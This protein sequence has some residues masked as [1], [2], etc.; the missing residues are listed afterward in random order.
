MVESLFFSSQNKILVV[1]SK[2][3]MFCALSQNN[4]HLFKKMINAPY[5]KLS[6]ELKNGIEFMDQTVKILF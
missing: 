6:K 3:T 4:Q 1:L 5:R 2:I